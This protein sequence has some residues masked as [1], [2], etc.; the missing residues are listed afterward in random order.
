MIA[1]MS[2]DLREEMDDLGTTYK[3]AK[4]RYRDAQ[5]RLV[6]RIPAWVE[7]GIKQHEIVE[8]TGLTREYIRQ[9][10]IKASD[11]QLDQIERDLATLGDDA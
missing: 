1:T 7:G 4:R 10:A 5:K 9:V 2:D 8:A 3:R 11:R 6:D